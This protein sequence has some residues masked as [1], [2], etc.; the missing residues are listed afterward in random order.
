MCD[1][2]YQR[3]RRPGKRP[4]LPEEREARA[5]VK[6]EKSRVRAAAWLAAN[7]ERAATSNAA[8]YAANHEKLLA[9]SRARY[10]A[11]PQKANAQNRAWR[12]ANR[13]R[14]TAHIA[15]YYQAN[16]E[17]KQA[18][19]R[20]Y[21][22][23]NREKRL[24]YQAAYAAVNPVVIQ[25]NRWRYRARK[26]NAPVN[27]LTASEWREVLEEYGHACA[28]CGRDDLSL[29]Q[30]HIY[31]LSRGG[32]HTR[33]NIAPACRSCNAMKSDHIVST[34]PAVVKPQAQGEAHVR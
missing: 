31:P 33:S 12:A 28:Y 13:E 1:T 16:K 5:A 25:A 21:Y 15:A 26:V 3:W 22:A 17:V 8:Y 20:A 7:P 18:S 27:D 4:V 34:A 6:R 19:T 2:H 24:A 23:A 11:D 32:S 30:D 14:F 9:S 10:R 29:E